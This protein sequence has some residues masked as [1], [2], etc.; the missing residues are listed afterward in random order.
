M[1]YYNKE[2][3][4][5]K[6]RKESAGSDPYRRDPYDL[7]LALE[8]PECNLDEDQIVHCFLLSLPRTPSALPDLNLQRPGC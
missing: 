3:L 1:L 4:I 8:D 7:W 2:N 6:A 5:S